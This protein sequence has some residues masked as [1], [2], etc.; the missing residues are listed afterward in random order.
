M[1]YRIQCSKLWHE[2]I[3]TPYCS[4]SCTG[5]MLVDCCYSSYIGFICITD[6]ESIWLSQLKWSKYVQITAKSF[7]LHVIFCAGTVKCRS[8]FQASGSPQHSRTRNSR[9]YTLTWHDEDGMPTPSC[10]VCS[11]ACGGQELLSLDKGTQIRHRLQPQISLPLG[12]GRENM[13]W[14]MIHIRKQKAH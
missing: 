8:A 2:Q 5:L 11:R 14:Q 3:K 12:L 6:G 9:R 13:G 10:T 7:V 1:Q 4:S